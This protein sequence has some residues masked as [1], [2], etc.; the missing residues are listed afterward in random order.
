MTHV[1]AVD[2]GGTKTLF[3]LSDA[4]GQV[5]H[6]LKLDSQRFDTFDVILTAFIEQLSSIVCY[7]HCLCRTGG[8]GEWTIWP[9]H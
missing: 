8:S 2:V 5:T 4:N 1:L 9:S 6:K 3:E 7:Q